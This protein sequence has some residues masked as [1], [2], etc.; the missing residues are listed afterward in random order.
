LGVLAITITKLLCR[1]HRRANGIPVEELSDSVNLIPPSEVVPDPHS[2]QNT[3][4]EFGL[5]QCLV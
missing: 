3:T 1:F 2:S 5:R 4:R